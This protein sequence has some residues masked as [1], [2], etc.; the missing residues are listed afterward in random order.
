MVKV[1]G[2]TLQ[3]RITTDRSNG[4]SLR[5][6]SQIRIT[7][8]LSNGKSLRQNSQIR[9]T[10]DLSNG[11]SLPQTETLRLYT[12]EM[13]NFCSDMTLIFNIYK[14]LTLVMTLSNYQVS[15]VKE[16]EVTLFS[17]AG[18]SSKCHPNVQV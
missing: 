14:L 13:P 6:N 12:T 3:I 18:I 8:D 7:T 10:T 2:R 9:I 5:Q 4:K 11:K 1:L 15:T 17:I 16:M